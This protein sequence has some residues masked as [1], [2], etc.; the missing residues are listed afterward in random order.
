MYAYVA[1]LHVWL[2]QE[3]KRLHLVILYLT[4]K[5]EYL[6]YQRSEYA[7]LRADR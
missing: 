6:I 7:C 3:N 5:Y 2:F 1:V 4:A